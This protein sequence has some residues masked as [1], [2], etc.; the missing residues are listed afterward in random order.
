MQLKPVASRNADDLRQELPPW[1]DVRVLVD[2]LDAVLEGPLVL[3][4]LVVVEDGGDGDGALQGVNSIDN[5][6]LEH[7]T[8]HET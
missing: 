8:G 3:H 2:H 7:E 1:Q 4:V 6:I 5:M